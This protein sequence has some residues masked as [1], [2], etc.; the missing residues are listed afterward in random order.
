MLNLHIN[1]KRRGYSQGRTNEFGWSRRGIIVDAFAGGGGVSEGIKWATGRSPNLAINHKW[2]AIQM[3][4]ANH[5]ETKHL[6]G[7]MWDVDPLAATEGYPVLLAWFSPDCTFFSSA[8]GKKPLRDEEIKVRHLASVVIR[9]A[10]TVKPRVIMLENVVEFQ[11]WGPVNEDGYPI[12]EKEGHSF[13]RWL[14]QLICAGYKVEMRQLRAC[15]YGAPTTRKRF[16]LIARCDGMP[17]AWPEPTHGPGCVRPYRT[18]AECIDWSIP[19]PSI[20]ERKEHGKKDLVEA[21]LRRIGKGVWRFV[22]N[23]GDPFLI[24]AGHRGDDRAHSIRD[25]IRTITS[26]RRGDFA[27]IAPTLVKYYQNSKGQTTQEPLHTVTTENR[28]ALIA[29]TLISSGYGERKGQEPRVLGLD[30]PLRTAVAGGV[31]AALIS[32]L[33]TK[34]Y[35]ERKGGWNGGASLNDPLPTITTRD[36]NSLTMAHMLKFYGTCP[37]GQDF[38]QPFPTITAKG[39]HF[40]EVRT[41]LSRYRPE[42][43]PPFDGA[44]E[45]HGSQY[46]VNDIGYRLLE[47]RE[48]YRGNGFRDNY[49][50]DPFDGAKERIKTLQIEMVGNSVPPQL[51][52]ALVRAN[53]AELLAAA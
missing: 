47:P 25:P 19:C 53:V 31:K 40:A 50:I 7:D 34:N 10:R 21:T 27:F 42:G 5:P 12:K 26:S 28:F 15:D 2:E 4:M 35:S 16:F 6:L 33:L 18:A 23:C 22:I 52:E 51:A 3:H 13:R 8:R 1:G 44:I 32:A 49:I 45:I 29:P 46:V 43:Q 38:R 24:P 48:L 14:G 11:K 37:D 17:I 20:F 41:L 36:H 9:W 39:N 30:K